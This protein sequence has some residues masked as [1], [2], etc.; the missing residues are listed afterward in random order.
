MA[1]ISITT[2][3]A[4]ISYPALFAPRPSP[5]GT[6]KFGCCLIFPQGTDLAE[7]E[8]ALR[9]A[10]VDRFGPKA[11]QQLKEGRLRWPL[12]DG[13][14][15]PGRP[16]YEPGA[17]FINTSSR[18]QPGCVDKYAGSGGRPR[19]ITDHSLIYPGCLVRASLVPFAYS[20]T[21]N[22]GV[23]ALLNA[24][25]LLDSDETRYPR[26]DGRP[27]AEWVFEAVEAPVDVDVVDEDEDD[28]RSVTERLK[29]S[30]QRSQRR[31]IRRD[32]DAPWGEAAE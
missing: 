14:E 15:R 5:D 10:A 1:R 31:R 8:A 12:R 24:V 21:G 11:L 7:L 25:Q 23:S 3:P 2:P 6:E 32:D 28:D 13:S 18:L 4:L 20:V 17:K 26:I 9:D 29:D 19:P 22:S 30:A 16:G 27:S